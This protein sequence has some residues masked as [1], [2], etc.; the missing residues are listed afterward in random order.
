MPS[1]ATAIERAKKFKYRL[2]INGLPVAMV[3]KAKPGKREVGISEKA[4]GGQNFPTKEAGMLKYGD[5]ELEVVLPLD[6]PGRVYFEKWMDKEQ[7]P[8]T[9][10]GLRPREYKQDFTLFW[11]RPDGNPLK[12]RHYKGGLVKDIDP[13]E[14]DSNDEKDDVIDKMTLAYDWYVDAEM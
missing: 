4:G 5:V 1:E 9:G 14:M 11:L 8:R 6:G 2:E 3:Q 12:A 10:N 7:D 13:G